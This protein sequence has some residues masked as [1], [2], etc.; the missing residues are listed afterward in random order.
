[1]FAPVGDG[2]TRRRGS[3]GLRVVVMVL[4]V[5]CCWL[6]TLGV[7]A[8]E[9]SVTKFL[10]NVPNGVQ[11]VVS[12]V[13][14]LGSIGTIVVLVVLSLVAKRRNVARDIALAGGAAFLVS[15]AL[16]FVIGP[17][18]AHT[19][20]PDLAGINLGFPLA[21]IAATIAVGTAALP[22]LSRAFQRLVELVIAL[23]SVA[24]VV[25]GSGLPV[26]VVASLAIGW[27]MT[28]IVHLVFGSPLGLP[29]GD[30]VEVLVRDLGVGAGSVVPSQRQIWG[31]ARFSGRDGTGPL[32]VSVYGRDAHDAQLLA[33]VFRFICYR[34][35]GPTLTFTRIQ[36][37]EHEAFLTLMAGRSGA[38]APEVLVAGRAGPARD[39]V[40]VTRPPSGTRLADLPAPAPAPGLPAPRG[41]LPSASPGG[42]AAAALVDG[43]ERPAPPVATGPEDERPEDQKPEDQKEA[44]AGHGEATPRAT[45]RRAARRARREAADAEAAIAAAAAAVAAVAPR[46]T[47]EAFSD[48]AADDLL[49]QVLKLRQDGIAHGAVS[50]ETVVAGP[51]GTVGLVDFRD[52]TVSGRD[53]RLE[54]DLAAALV[55]LGQA[56]GPERAIAAAARVLPTDVLAAAL[57]F[58]QRAAL[59]PVASKSLRG[60]KPLLVALRE[61]GAEA[62]GVEVPELAEPRRISWV[63]LIMIIGSLIGGW[64]LI[65]VLI[66]VGKS[67]STITGAKWGWVA[68]CFVLAQAVYPAIAVTTT[69]SIV[70]PLSFGRVLALEVSNTFVSLAGGTMAVLAA[71]VRFFQ[72]DGYDATLAVS[73]GAVCSTASWIVKGGLFLI[74]LPFAISN[75]HFQKEPTS[76][77]GG[78]SGLVWLILLVVIGVVVLLGLVFLVPRLRRLARDKL[79]PK[80]S[81][82]WAH[83]KILAVHPRNLIEIFGGSIVAQLLVAMALGAALHAFGDHLSLAILLVVLTLGSM[84]GGISPVPGGMGVVEAGMIIGLTAA[85]ISESDAVAAVFVQ[86]LF[87]AYLPPIWGW[88]VLLWLRKREYL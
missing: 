14:W 7:A 86:R 65:A 13:L 35:S 17:N 47:A 12:A 60:R 45:G 22:Y 41:A 46:V 16:S 11:W 24:T 63:N 8:P 83:L 79:R 4:A 30:E 36:Q 68:A 38:R 78:D 10:T 39:A 33:K 66:N 34:D 44:T 71:R 9:I 59:D 3:D 64:A 62:A 73:S 55:T 74:A 58:I 52:A 76:S 88:F 31:V 84:L 54:R 19:P 72:Q 26:A 6:I 25:H 23:A 80:L 21:R 69:G 32:E 61:Q 42:A 85:G 57:P 51:A 53:E 77:S 70:D 40:L 56:T 49:R 50:V 20:T 82:A 18:G 15:L 48:D 43:T 87:T 37:V 81:E 1:V 67:W 28:A 27:G 5:L 2:A 29:S 75:L